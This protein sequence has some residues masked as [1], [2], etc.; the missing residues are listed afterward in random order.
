M[1]YTADTGVQHTTTYFNRTIDVVE[2]HTWVD[3]QALS[4]F[5]LILAALGGLGELS[6]FMSCL[7]SSSSRARSPVCGHT[8][9][10]PPVCSLD[11]REEMQPCKQLCLHTPQEMQSSTARC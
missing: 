4:L 11:G 5:F 10:F 1:F 9:L 2:P 8:V 6:C 3:F 7:R